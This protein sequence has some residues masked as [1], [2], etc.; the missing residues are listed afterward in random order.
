MTAASSG[1]PCCESG[2]KH[3][4][5]CH[6]FVFEC[7]EETTLTRGTNKER[8]RST[9]QSPVIRRKVIVTPPPSE[10]GGL[11]RQGGGGQMPITDYDAAA[12]GR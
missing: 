2:A 3:E 1:H 4:R 6:T 12:Y 8:T 10:G 11:S 5:L 9:T 7:E